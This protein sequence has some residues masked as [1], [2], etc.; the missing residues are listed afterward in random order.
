VQRLCDTGR[1]AAVIAELG[2]LPARELETSPTLAL[3]F[4]I[5]QGR[6]GHH[7]TGK[8][9]VETALGIARSRGDDTI[10]ARSLNVAGAIAFQEGRIDEAV[11]CFILGLAESERTVDRITMGRCSNNLGIIANLRGDHGRAVGCYTKALAAFQRAGHRAGAAETLHNLAITY[12]DQR[13]F[14]R[15]LDAEDRAAEEASASGDLAL[16]ALIHCGRGEIRLRTGEVELGRWEIQRALE[17][18]REVG[19]LRGEAEDLLALAAAFELQQQQARAEAILRD[20][21]NRARQIGQ[22]LLVAQAERDLAR[23]LHRQ[24]F[25]Y[26]ASLL[27][28]QARQRF[29]TLGAV[30]EVGRLDRM[31]QEMNL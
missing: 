25:D 1:N 14:A 24:K 30:A 8:R 31:L 3:L 10:E 11:R 27:A 2:A 15:A 9:W 17:L 12:R 23:L 18:H 21:A 6:L 16:V 5:A 19:D 22:A 13:A 4:G 20:V 26:E 7:G 29:A 28:R